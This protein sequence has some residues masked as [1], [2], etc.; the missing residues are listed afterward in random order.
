MDVVKLLERLKQGDETAFRDMVFHFSRRL[1][2]VAKLYSNSNEEAEDVLQDAYVLVYK[3]IGV[4]TGTEERAFYGW[5]K[6][7]VINLCLS[8]NQKKYRKMESSLDAMVYESG[9]EAEIETHLSHDD[10]MKLVFNLP[11]GYRQ[12]FALYAV[13]GYSH[14]EIGAMLNIAVSSSRS[15]YSRARKILQTQV[16]SLYKVM[17]A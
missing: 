14:K 15:R 10:L 2:T 1:M 8:R 13:E 12:V 16:N 5:M 7:I 11:E 17:I 3:K 6:R 4:F 9:R